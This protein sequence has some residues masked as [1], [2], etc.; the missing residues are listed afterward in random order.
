MWGESQ[1]KA[2]QE[3]KAALISSQTLCAFNP[4]LETIVSV[5]ASSFG[6][7]AVLRQRQPEDK[8]LHPVAYISRVLSD[9]E[10]N[11]AQIEKEAL[12]V[13]WACERF[14]NYLLGLHFQIETDHKPLVLLLSNKPLDQLPI[15]VQR[16]RLRMMRFDYIIAHVPGKQLQIADALSRAPVSSATDADYQFQKEVSAYVELMIQTLP[17]TVH[18]LQVVQE[19]QDSDV[20]CTQIKSYYQ[21]GWPDQMRLQG[22]LKQYFPV[23]DELSVTND[24]LLRGNRLVIPQSLRSEML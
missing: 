15:R 21:H 8:V 6:L 20:T 4:T 13:T 10:K 9:T 24:L 5:D 3:V 1:D 12:A 19:A 17:A 14:Q 11:Y 23:K 2:F 22:T 16:F 7:G 18:Q